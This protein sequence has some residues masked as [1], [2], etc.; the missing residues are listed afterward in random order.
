MWLVGSAQSLF[1]SSL[2]QRH[3]E[4]TVA[5]CSIPESL[6]KQYAKTFLSDMVCGSFTHLAEVCLKTWKCWRF[7][8]INER[9]TG[10]E[11]KQ[12]HTEV[13]ETHHFRDIK[14]DGIQFRLACW[15]VSS[16][17]SLPLFTSIFW[18]KGFHR[19]ISQH[20]SLLFLSHTGHGDMVKS[21][22]LTLIVVLLMVG[23]CPAILQLLPASAH[24]PWWT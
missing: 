15:S 5:V 23:Y 24:C 22:N 1:V 14:W 6:K 2:W 3:I 9:Q 12:V 4:P 20:S 13:Q 16:R 19:H 10:W 18:A 8:V 7:Y 11:N 17:L 21:A